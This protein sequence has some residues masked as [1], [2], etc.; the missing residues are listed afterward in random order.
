MLIYHLEFY[1][2]KM[3]QHIFQPHPV[4]PVCF[5]STVIHIPAFYTLPQMGG[6][7]RA[8]IAR[9]LLLPSEVVVFRIYFLIS[10]HFTCS[11]H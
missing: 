3:E 2:V 9:C 6:I 7:D 1:T 4:F 5:S 11:D 10:F 8:Q